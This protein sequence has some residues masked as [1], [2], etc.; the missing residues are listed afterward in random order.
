MYVKSVLQK[1]VDFFN[2]WQYY[3]IGTGQLIAQFIL[4]VVLFFCVFIIDESIQNYIAIGIIT[5][6]L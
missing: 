3:K 6:L 5:L 2:L 4:S 1:V